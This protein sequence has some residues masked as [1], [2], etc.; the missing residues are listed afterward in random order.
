MCYHVSQEKTVEQLKVAFRR[1]VDNIELFKQAFHVNAF[2]N[3]FQ[4]VIS[5]RNPRT[6]DM[7]RWRLVPSGVISEKTFG[8]NTRNARSE[9]IF[10]ANSYKPYWEN[11]CLIICTGFFEPHFISQDRPTHSYYI[12][13]KQREF[14]TLGG[15]FAPWQGMNTYSIITTEASPLLSEVHNE[16][17]RMP[18]VLEG[19]AARRWVAPPGAMTQDEMS[20]LMQPYLHDDNWITYR[21][22]DGITNSRAATNVPEVLLPYE[23]K[24]AGYTDLP[25]FGQNRDE[26]SD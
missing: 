25:L 13:S 9:T 6:I 22:I 3:P 1:P 12:K 7:Y 5:N 26:T 17:K 24:P 2:D 16:G 8:A 20:E 10:T 18:L 11:R 19:E 14:L 4:P 15:I 21:T 23:P